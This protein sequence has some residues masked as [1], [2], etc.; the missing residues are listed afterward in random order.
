MNAFKMYVGMP[1]VQI[2]WEVIIVV[3][4]LATHIK[5]ALVVEVIFLFYKKETIV[6]AFHR[7]NHEKWYNF[8][9][10]SIT[11]ISKLEFRP[12]KKRLKV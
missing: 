7:Q 2:C 1:H 6:Y 11:S 5:L 3:V 8:Y 10:E 9:L 4:Q 12:V